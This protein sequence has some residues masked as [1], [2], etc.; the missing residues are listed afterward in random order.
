MIILNTTSTVMRLIT[1]AAVAL[2]ACVTFLDTNVVAVPPTADPTPQRTAISTA[3]TTTV[4]SSPAANVDRGISHATFCARGGANVVTPQVHDGSTAFHLVGPTAGV[5]LASGETLQYT[6]SG[7]WSVL[8]P[9]GSIKY[10]LGPT[11]NGH[12]IKDNG[13]ARAQRTNI[14]TVSSPTIVFTATD[15]SG[16]DETELSCRP[17][18]RAADVADGAT[19]TLG[20]GDS[21]DLITS[22]TAITAFTFTSDFSGRVARVRFNTIRTL[23][24]NG[25]SLQILQT[26]ASITTAVGDACEVESIGSG[27]VRIRN[28][29]RASGQPLALPAASDTVSGIIELAIQA[30]METGTDVVRA[31]TPG[32]QHFHLSACKCWGFTTGAGTP[33]L[34]AQSYN[35]TSITDTATGRLTVTIGNDFSSAAWVGVLGAGIATTAA[36]ITGTVTKAAGTV[37]IEADDAADAAADPGTGWDWAFFGDLI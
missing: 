9:F 26:G 33:A 15:D 29:E 19:I 24:H 17:Q 21:F 10:V 16:S 2:D 5:S 27:N 13:T 37:I 34:N 35:M 25:T 22:T 20:N 4:A 32:R 7:G 3:T 23:T 36:R 11:L 30:E 14:N 18:G 6:A 8:D 31:V 12:V 28:Y 1:S